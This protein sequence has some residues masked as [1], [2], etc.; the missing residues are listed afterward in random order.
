MLL[1]A[2][3]KQETEN[4]VPKGALLLSAEDFVD[5]NGQKTSVLDNSVQWCNGDVVVI[6]ETEYT[7]IVDEENHTAYIDPSANPIGLQRYNFL[8]IP[9]NFSQK[10][11]S[12]YPRRRRAIGRVS[13]SC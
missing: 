2:C 6:N 4:N 1:S 9:A 3:Q 7:V 8:P 5:H 11:K 13:I 10:D 12:E